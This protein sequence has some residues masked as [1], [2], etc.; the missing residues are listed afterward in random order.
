VGG[1]VLV[2]DLEAHEDQIE[3]WLASVEAPDQPDA[4]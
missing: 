1:D 4:H 2:Y 3:R